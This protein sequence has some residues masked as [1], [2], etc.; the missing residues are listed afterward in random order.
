[1]PPMAFF[2][3]SLFGKTFME[4]WYRITGLILEPCLHLS[5]VPKFQALLLADGQEPVWFMGLGLSLP[6]GSWTP[7]IGVSP[8][9]VCAS[10]S[11][12]II[13]RD[14]PEKYYLSPAKCSRYLRCAAEAGCRP[15]PILE[16]ILLNQGGN[17]PSY[18]HLMTEGFEMRE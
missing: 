3:Q 13:E 10:S 15:F 18:F 8:S 5:Q 17:Y 16:R 4:L 14:V 1:M 7:N 2:Q 9:D 12:L 11:S 6:G